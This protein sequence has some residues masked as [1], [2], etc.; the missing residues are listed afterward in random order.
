VPSYDVGDGQ[1]AVTDVHRNRHVA[2]KERSNVCSQPGSTMAHISDDQNGGAWGEL[3][4]FVKVPM[5][6][7][8]LLQQLRVLYQGVH[9]FNNEKSRR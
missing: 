8:R 3:E 9:V 7:L 6:A 5:Q 2:S 4:S 1:R